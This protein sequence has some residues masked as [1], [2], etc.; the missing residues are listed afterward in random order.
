MTLWKAILAYDTHVR[1]CIHTAN[2]EPQDWG[3]FSQGAPFVC[4]QPRAA[5]SPDTTTPFV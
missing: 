1:V 4:V 3:N 5:P 2:Y